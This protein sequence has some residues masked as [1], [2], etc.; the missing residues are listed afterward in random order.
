MQ[1]RVEVKTESRLF[2]AD[3]IIGEYNIKARLRPN[4]SNVEKMEKYIQSLEFLGGLYYART[5]S[6][7]YSE[8]KTWKW[9]EIVNKVNL[10]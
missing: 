10:H 5:K 4:I 1:I 6:L 9:R 8:V 2:P 7:L 3:N